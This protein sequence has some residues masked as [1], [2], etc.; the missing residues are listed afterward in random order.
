[1][2]GVP[3]LDPARVPSD[4]RP[5]TVAL[6]GAYGLKVQWSDGHSTG[7]YTFQRLLQSCPCLRC[8]ERR[9]MNRSPG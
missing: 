9:Q 1:M 2:S 4:I 6:V 7:I 8:Q 3:L 5:V